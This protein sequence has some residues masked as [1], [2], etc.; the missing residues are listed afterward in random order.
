M[1]DLTV[2]TPEVLPPESPGPTG[3]VDITN[4]V[5]N[6]R[7]SFVTWGVAYVYGIE[8]ATPGLEWVALPVIAEL[9]RAAVKAILDAITKSVVM[10]AFFLN[11]AIRK[12][13]QAADYVDTVNAKKALAENGSEAEYEAAEKAEMLA[14]RNFVMVTN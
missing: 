5:E 7:S 10:E 3:T 8:I 6:L 14:F 2:K 4:V 11:T 9:D 1:T 13:S 12:A